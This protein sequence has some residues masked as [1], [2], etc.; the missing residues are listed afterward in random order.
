M[1]IATVAVS[2]PDLH[3]QPAASSSA[4][5]GAALLSY[6]VWLLLVVCTQRIETEPPQ[7]IIPAYTAGARVKPS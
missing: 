6:R 5:Q 7:T 1:R 4:V 2:A 3:S